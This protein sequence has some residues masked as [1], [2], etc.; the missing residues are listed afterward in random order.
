MKL[1]ESKT[2]VRL[3]ATTMAED[4][5]DRPS[6]PDSFGEWELVNVRPQFSTVP[7]FQIV[8]MR[9]LLDLAAREYCNRIHL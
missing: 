5:A 2:I 4:R 9:E 6:D 8:I 7:V 3:C 1:Q